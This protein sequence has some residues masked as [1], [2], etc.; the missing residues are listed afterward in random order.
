MTAPEKHDKHC[1]ID[2]RPPGMTANTKARRM[3][4]IHRILGSATLL[5]ALAWPAAMAATLLLGSLGGCRIDEGGIY[6]CVVLG[7]DI[8]ELAATLGVLAAWGSMIFIPLTF[9]LAGLWLAI[10]LIAALIRRLR[11]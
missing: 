7:R 10:T 2:N 6:P 9:A 8:G 1:T 11:R 5:A 4:W 3:T